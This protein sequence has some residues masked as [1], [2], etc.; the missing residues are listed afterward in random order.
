MF[1][2]VDEG[3]LHPPPARRAWIPR[4]RL[5][6][7]LSRATRLPVTVIAAP[8]GYGKSTVV[9]Q[10]LGSGRAPAR[11]AWVCLDAG[12]NDSTRFWTH[13]VSALERIG[14]AVDDNP[15][16]FVAG[17]GGAML[18]RVV[19]RVAE[20]LA[21]LGEPLTIVLDDAHLLLSPDC[22]A[23]L[24]ALID[25]LPTN[26]QLILISRSEPALRLSRLRLDGRLAE[27]RS[28]TLSFT[29]GEVRWLL[30]TEGLVLSP[31]AVSELLARTEGWPAAIYLAL[32]SLRG[33]GDPDAFVRELSGNNR[34]I[35]DYLSEEVLA[36]EDPDLREFI[37]DMSLFDRFNAALGDSVTGR[38]GS[39]GMIRRLARTNLF[40]IPLDS[41]E[42]WVRFHHL[43]ASFARGA[44]AAEDAARVPTL[45][46]RGAEWFGAHD[47]IDEAIRHAIAGGA[48]DAAAAL[49]Q[50]SWTRYFEAGR[51]ATVAGWIRALDATSAHGRAPLELTAAWTAALTG[52]RA[53]LNRRLTVLDTLPDTGPLPDGTASIR[54]ATALLRGLFGFDGPDQL[55][56]ESAVAAEL[57]TDPSS[58]W[59]AVARAATGHAA[60]VLGDLARARADLLEAAEA[61]RAA[62]TVR[63]LG[64]GL[65]TL[66]DLESGDLESARQT[67]DHSMRLVRDRALEAMPSSLW[68]F[69]AV[70]GV[71]LADGDPRGAL[72][73]LDEGLQI[74]RRL[75]GAHTLAADLP[76]G[77]DGEGR[78]S[79]NPDRPRPGADGRAG[80]TRQL[81]RPDDGRHLR[82]DRRGPGRAGRPGGERAGRPRRCRSPGA[83]SRCCTGS[84][85]PRACARSP[86]TCTCRTTP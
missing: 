23:Q 75:P 25:R 28:R 74:R 6:A 48:D 68:G 80:G 66:C 60:Y 26:V 43:F 58:P 64:L 35:A 22:A 11:Q 34:F 16:G 72:E 61:P 37:L 76:P 1:D 27:I 78:H 15:I 70:G 19:P 4:P 51:A 65:A 18:T 41:G 30:R 9:T 79:S 14:C 50:R 8:A 52:Q 20:A 44:L 33:R 81:A 12:D 57:E 21:A 54:S 53:E 38:P 5:L 17:S 24:D 73:I 55:I 40:L 56:A 47:Q 32:L 10:W 3:K 42:G 69:T 83:R 82:P 71:R 36:R 39:A 67:A 45:H 63:V 29:A 46:L 7:E 77:G 2:S 62:T 31:D 84:A 13:L 85:E 86:A 49:I 59:Y